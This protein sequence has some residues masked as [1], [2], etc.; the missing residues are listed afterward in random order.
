MTEEI[1]AKYH[2]FKKRVYGTLTVVGF[3][4]F[5]A[6]LKKAMG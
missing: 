4:L 6:L 5:A 2:R 3:V 1:T